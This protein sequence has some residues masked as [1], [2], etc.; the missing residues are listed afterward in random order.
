MYAP[1]KHNHRLG[2][3]LCQR[4]NADAH[5][6]LF[7]HEQACSAW[8]RNPESL[9]LQERKVLALNV[10]LVAELNLR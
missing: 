6:Y 1:F 5:I 9:H 3:R 4:E 8:K 10:R 7:L 2:T